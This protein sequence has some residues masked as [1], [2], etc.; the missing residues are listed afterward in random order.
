MTK[1]FHKHICRIFGAFNIEE[2]NLLVSDKFIDA[3]MVYI[4]VLVAIFSPRILSH[5]NGSLIIHAYAKGFDIVF[6]FTK[7]VSNPD[8]LPST[9]ICGNI[10]F[11]GGIGDIL[12]LARCPGES[13]TSKLG[14]PASV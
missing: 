8:G 6:H 13:S 14:D 1:T 2:F 11:S 12:L 9:I 10:L 4:N 7:N 5:E 3:F